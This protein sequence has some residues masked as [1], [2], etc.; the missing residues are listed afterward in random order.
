MLQ[1]APGSDPVQEEF[2][3]KQSIKN[4]YQTFGDENDEQWI[5]ERKNTNTKVDKREQVFFCPYKNEIL[6]LFFLE[7]NSLKKINSKKV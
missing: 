3:I 2:G 1:D 4:S 6:G 7:I 5:K